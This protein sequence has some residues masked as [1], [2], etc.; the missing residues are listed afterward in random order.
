MIQKYLG[1][2]IRKFR[3][4]IKFFKKN[5]EES[6][7]KNN[8]QFTTLPKIK[9]A[10]L[11]RPEFC[12]ISVNE[13]CFF[14]CKMCYKWKPD[15]FIPEDAEK[16][17]TNDLKKFIF[18]LRQTVDKGFLINFAG[19]ET[20]LR[21]DFFE[22]IKYAKNLGF[23]TNLASN[24]YL[25]DEKMAKNM[26][27]SGL[28]SI[29]FS[30]DGSNAE[31]H[32][33]MRGRKGSF[34]KLLK[35]IDLLVSYREKKGLGKMEFRIAAQ[36]VICA[37]NLEDI[38]SLV[39]FIDNHPHILSIKFNVVMEPNNTKPDP[40]WYKGK[41]SFLWPK[42]MS[43][44][45][46]VFDQLIRMRKENSKIPDELFQLE[47]YRKYF[48][49]PNKF[50]KLGHCNFDKSI[51]LSSTGDM[52]LCFNYASIGNIKNI[53]FVDAWDSKKAKKVR[54]EIFKCTKN[55]HFLINCNLDEN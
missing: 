3:K 11:V 1:S 37:L 28:S 45:D 14:K 30:I 13:E 54:S 51:N 42:D 24:G 25:I 55:C 38:P 33:E 46:R 17:T 18:G 48:K 49:D 23:E 22:V 8:Q 6:N 40:K 44:V 26:I 35:A 15:I 32:D 5:N 31:I 4:N 29:N 21:K 10:L 27:D 36:A 9:N 41:Y 47:A 52:F 2:E 12:N 20:L 39:S 19:G 53:D 43:I 16:L 7:L 34:E 50:I